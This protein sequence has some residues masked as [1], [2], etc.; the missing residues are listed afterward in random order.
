VGI[1]TLVAMP[2]LAL[3]LAETSVFFDFDGTLSAV[4]I[5]KHLL[6]RLGPPE[7]RDIERRFICG[8]IS[9]RECVLDHWEMLPHDET[10]LRDV[11]R[12]VPLDPGFA[13]LLE[14]LRRAGAEVTVVS[15]GFGFYVHEHCAPFGVDV[16]TNEPDFATGRLEF[17]HEDRCCACSSC[18][19]CKQ[20]P[21]KDARYR[22]RTTVL[23][24][25]GTSDAKAALLCDVVFAKAELGVWCER[26]GVAFTPYETLADVAALLLGTQS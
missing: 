12:E 24:G 26:S 13:P 15:D 2:T 14:V 20:A 9:S 22:G 5:G 21:V 23:V 25:D 6:E 16:L 7:W 1:G 8:E 17:P 19:T 10:L 3:D 4:D 11:A 18:G